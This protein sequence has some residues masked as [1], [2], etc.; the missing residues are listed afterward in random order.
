MRVISY[1][2]GFRADYAR[3]FCE[4]LIKHLGLTKSRYFLGII[5]LKEKEKKNAG[6]VMHDEVGIAMFLRMDSPWVEFCHSIA[7]E[8]IHVKQ[9]ATGRLKQH[10][11][12]GEVTW[13]GR[14]YKKKDLPP[15]L[16]RPWELQAMQHET[17]L[18]RMYEDH[19]FTFVRKR[20]RIK[21]GGHPHETNVT[22]K[23][24]QSAHSGQRLRRK[25]LRLPNGS[26]Q[27]RGN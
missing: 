25:V 20:G 17:I 16:A 19:L 8:M 27:R 5:P 4:Y 7:H 6:L 22:R 18:V 14:R 1:S 15:L 9:I 26:S 3:E 24:V 13:L 12:V 10:I 21:P 23:V 11:E 2:K